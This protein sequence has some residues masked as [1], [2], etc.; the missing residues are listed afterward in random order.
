M[1]KLL[2]IV[3]LGL[4]LCNQPLMSADLD[5]DKIDFDQI[6]PIIYLIGVLILV[7]PS[8]LH[9]NSKLKQLLANLSIWVIILLI[10]TTISYFLLK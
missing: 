1:K 5:Y 8:F 6:I 10:V 2:G 4:L 3:V 9:S 7:M